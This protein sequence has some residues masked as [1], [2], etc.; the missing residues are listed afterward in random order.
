MQTISALI[1]TSNEE[2]NI[3]DCLNS[4]GWVDEI[5]IIDSYSI[6]RTVD[7]CQKYTNK[8]Y[9]RKFDD[10]ASQRNYGLQQVH[11]EWV[12]I[13][14]A[15]ERVSSELKLEIKKVLTAP[16]ADAYEIPFHN[17]FLGKWIR[18]CGWYPDYHLRLFLTTKGQFI[19]KVH[20]KVQINGTTNK[21]SKAIVHFTYNSISQFIKKT[22][23]YTNLAAKEMY[24]RGKSFRITD[25]IARPIWR[26]CKMYLFKHGYKDGVRGLILSFLYSV[27]VFLKYAKLWDINRKEVDKNVVEI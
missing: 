6:D 19:N 17:Y 16:Q 3:T 24:L 7:I 10:F 1:I 11:S 4:I 14:D 8:I 9:K 15:D 5:V 25:L 27:Y 20:E 26:F 2:Q 13:I 21:L 18:H 23:Y 22:D 12:L